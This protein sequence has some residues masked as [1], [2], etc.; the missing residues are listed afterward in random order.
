MS[1]ERDSRDSRGSRAKHG[2]NAR[3]HHLTTSSSSNT[4]KIDIESSR[5]G[6]SRFVDSD[7]DEVSTKH[8]MEMYMELYME[9][10]RGEERFVDTM[11]SMDSM[12]SM[13]S[14]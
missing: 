11:D 8:E 13:G 2:V 5:L 14:I 10:A 9:K 6:G 12:D 7:E 4:I 1:E 3:C